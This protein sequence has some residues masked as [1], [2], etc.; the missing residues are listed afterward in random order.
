MKTVSK[1][2]LQTCRWNIHCYQ[3]SRNCCKMDLKTFTDKI[4][5]H[6]IDHCARLS[7]SVFNPNK[8]PDATIISIFKYGYQFIAHQTN[9][10][11]A[12]MVSLPTPKS[13]K[14]ANPLKQSSKQLLQNQ[15]GVMV[16][17]RATIWS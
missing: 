2:I 8:N 5:L 15:P 14:C 12:M 4:L 16:L 6:L 9:S 11:M 3:F 13:L 10:Y 17:L 7:A 1:D